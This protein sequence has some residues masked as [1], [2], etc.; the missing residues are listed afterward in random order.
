M[1]SSGGATTRNWTE[2]VEDLVHGGEVDRAISFLE[3]TVSN[4]ES[5]LEKELQDN[6]GGGS[7]SSIA[8]QLSTALEDLSKLYSAEGFSLRADQTFSR[9]LQIKHGRG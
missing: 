9:A 3:S 5:E 6:N 7:S 4:L 1:E 8:D 2:E